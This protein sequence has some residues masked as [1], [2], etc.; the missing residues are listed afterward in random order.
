MDD[1]QNWF[2]YTIDRP[3]P[4][5]RYSTI[6]I[7]DS[8]L[9]SHFKS[10]AQ[11]DLELAIDMDYMM[12]PTNDKGFERPINPLA[13]MVYDLK[14][15]TILHFDLIHPDEETYE[16]IMDNFLGA[17]DHFGKPKNVYAR[18]PYI[19]SWLEFICDT[20]EIPLIQDD[21]DELDDIFEMLKQSDI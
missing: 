19:L 1:E 16:V 18:N 20:L 15:N 6:Y 10:L 3:L 9:I 5:D 17:L 13:F 21:L 2:S 8:N 4:P 12:V 14:E 7:N 11:S